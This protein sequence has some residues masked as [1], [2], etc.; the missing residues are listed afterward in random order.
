MTRRQHNCPGRSLNAGCSGCMA[1]AFTAWCA[2]MQA[3][4]CG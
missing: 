2:G 4:G 1:G 3:W